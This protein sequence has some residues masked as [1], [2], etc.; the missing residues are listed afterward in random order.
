L[1]DYLRRHGRPG[2]V[3]MTDAATAY[4]LYGLLLLRPVA[5]L[6]QHVNP[7]DPTAMGRLQAV[8]RVMS[9]L[10]PLSSGIRELRR[11]R[12]R[13]LAVDGGGA[14]EDLFYGRW[15]PGWREE[16]EEKFS[17]QPAVDLLWRGKGITLFEVDPEGEWR[18]SAWGAS[19]PYL[20]EGETEP[21]RPIEAPGFRIVGVG[22]SRDRALPGDTLTITLRYERQGDPPAWP[23]RMVIRLD[24]ESLYRGP[25]WPG[26]R[27]WR[28]RRERIRDRFMRVRVDRAP[29][30]GRFQPDT[31][32]ILMDLWDRVRVRLPSE[33]APGTYR[34]TLAVE[35]A[36]LVPNYRL[37]EFLFDLDRFS[38]PT[39]ATLDVV[40]SMRVTR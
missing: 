31:W 2:D 18:P 13:W 21:C 12:V 33:L 38:K 27:W 17:G 4:R 28:R 40:E 16:L 14:A 34:L 6:H 22:L 30:D 39:G 8:H 1:A 3:V 25:H 37:R 32:P 24:H 26:E 20:L 7:F 23:L 11:F 19:N 10:Q 5:I 9:P 29:C 35:P 15:E 36:S